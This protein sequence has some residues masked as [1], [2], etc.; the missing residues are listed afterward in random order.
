MIHELKL[1]KEDYNSTIIF[2]YTTLTVTLYSDDFCPEQEK[3]TILYSSDFLNRQR[4]DY[5]ITLPHSV[6][7][8]CGVISISVCKHTSTQK[9]FIAIMDKYTKFTT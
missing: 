1:N 2:T 5:L 6:K 7:R 8:I 3:Q 4:R 9:K